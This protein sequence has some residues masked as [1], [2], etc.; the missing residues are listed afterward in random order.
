VLPFGILTP[1]QKAYLT[2]TVAFLDHID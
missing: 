2:I 1:S